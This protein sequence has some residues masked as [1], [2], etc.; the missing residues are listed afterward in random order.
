MRCPIQQP[1]C[2]ASQQPERQR[3]CSVL[4]IWVRVKISRPDRINSK[5]ARAKHVRERLGVPRTDM[6]V[7]MKKQSAFGGADETPAPILLVRRRYDQ[8]PAR[9]LA[10]NAR[11]TDIHAI[12]DHTS[13][14]RPLSEALH[15]RSPSIR[16]DDRSYGPRENPFAC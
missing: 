2:P 5:S 8:A 6:L 15:Q 12:R 4:R 11:R 7:P 13:A 1:F 14:P 16:P 3:H 9:F 10:G